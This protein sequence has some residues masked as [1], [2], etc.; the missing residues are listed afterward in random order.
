MKIQT[1]KKNGK[2]IYK[3]KVWIGSG[4]LERVQKRFSAESKAELKKL[5][6]DAES[7]HEDIKRL[8][9]GSDVSLGELMKEWL[10]IH[11]SNEELAPAT[12]M[13]HRHHIYKNLLVAPIHKKQINDITR[14]D[15]EGFHA[16][17]KQERK[18]GTRSVQSCHATIRAGMNWALSHNRVIHNPFMSTKA[19]SKKR[20][21]RRSQ[22]SIDR[23]RII[24]RDLWSRFY[25]KIREDFDLSI[26]R[27]DYFDKQRDQ[28]TYT[29]LFTTYLTGM[30]PEET[31][32]LTWKDID[33]KKKIIIIKNAVTETKEGD[34]ATAEN[35]KDL[36]SKI[37]LKGTKTGEERQITMGKILETNLRIYKELADEYWADNKFNNEHD[38]LFP[39]PYGDL[40]SVKVL[41]QRFKNVLREVGNSFEQN[42]VLYDL[43][44]THASELIDMGNDIVKI[45]NRL[46][47]TSPVT[48]L[49]FY[50]HLIPNK[51]IEMIDS[52]EESL[53]DSL[54]HG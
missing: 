34:I 18:L 25:S 41:S 20:T 43:R 10:P 45:S 7:K 30:R 21:T 38:V 15:I 39:T 31:L 19:P 32:G 13:T 36:K 40:M 6:A 50:A 2:T 11:S 28:V 35:I 29:A 8:V 37:I 27:N 26:K 3:T 9:E 46:G 44:H 22:N 51:D 48:T 47:H 23:T 42:H 12:V 14:K 24:S 54:N 5:I 1:I 49:S 17:L 4:E 53:M 33:F 52:Y 16:F